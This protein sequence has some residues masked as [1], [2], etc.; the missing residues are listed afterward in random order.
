MRKIGC[1]TKEGKDVVLCSDCTR[2]T[3]LEGCIATIL[4]DELCFV[5]V[6]CELTKEMIRKYGGGEE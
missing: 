5:F 3:N 1:G 4:E 6:D 2:R